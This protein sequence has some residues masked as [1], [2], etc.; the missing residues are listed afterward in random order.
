M[1][2][3]M[4]KRKTNETNIK[5]S[6]NLDGK[7]KC[8]IDLPVG[9]MKH[10]LELFAK[11]SKMDLEVK[12]EGDTYV[13]NHHLI[14]DLGIVM[15]NAIKDALGDKK[16]INRYGFFILPM[17]ETL[18]RVSLDFSGRPYFV[19]KVI[20]SKVKLGDM[21]FELL[22][23]FWQSFCF[24]AKMNLHIE[25][26]YGSNLHHIAEGIFKAVA[27]S[28]RMAITYDKGFENDIPSTKGMI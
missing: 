10:M 8:S 9:F 21:E 22:K 7:G 20:D 16:G 23:E 6:V 24:N 19:W 3:S 5:V 18:V 17:D 26:L 25:L 1:R 14:E 15:G 4:I 2:K 11:H 27:K 12:A 28:M 13:D